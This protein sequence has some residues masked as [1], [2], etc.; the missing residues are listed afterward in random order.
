MVFLR[1]KKRGVSN[2]RWYVSKISQENRAKDKAT[3]KER[4]K[5]IS[6][7]KFHFSI[8]YVLVSLKKRGRRTRRMSKYHFEFVEFS[9]GKEAAGGF[10]SV[11]SQLHSSEQNPRLLSQLRRNDG[12]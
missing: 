11:H 3:E 7:S 8:M 12:H 1:K 2:D 9:F 10:K 4:K 5:K 6:V